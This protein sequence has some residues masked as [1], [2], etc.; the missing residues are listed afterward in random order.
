MGIVAWSLGSGIG[1][2]ARRS[3]PESRGSIGSVGSK[4]HKPSRV[5]RLGQ[6]LIWPTYGTDQRPAA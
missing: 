4:V 1:R 3:G 6:L 2:E 5:R